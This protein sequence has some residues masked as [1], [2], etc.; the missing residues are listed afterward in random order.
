[1]SSYTPALATWPISFTNADTLSSACEYLPR[2]PGGSL[3]PSRQAPSSRVMRVA[4]SWDIAHDA[5][6]GAA[7]PS[8]AGAGTVTAQHL[9]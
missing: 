7:G 9:R 4:W 3:K 5:V 6:V 2:R 8:A 1:M